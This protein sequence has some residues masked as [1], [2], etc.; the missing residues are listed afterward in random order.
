[1]FSAMASAANVYLANGS[2]QCMNINNLANMPFVNDGYQ[3]L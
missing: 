3:I 2:R 1:M